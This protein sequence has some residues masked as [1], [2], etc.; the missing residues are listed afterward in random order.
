MST[1]THDVDIFET[2]YDIQQFDLF[3]VGKDDQENFKIDL[4][5]MYNSCY[6][7]E[8]FFSPFLEFHVTALDSLGLFKN[9]PLRGGELLRIKFKIKS[10]IIQEEKTLAFRLISWNKTT[11]KDNLELYK[12][13]IFMSK[14]YYYNLSSRINWA[15]PKETEL[16]S[17]VENICEKLLHCKE[18]NKEF[19]G[20]ESNKLGNSSSNQFTFTNAPPLD[21]IFKLIPFTSTKDDNK[22]CDYLFFECLDAGNKVK[23]NFK[24]LNK[25]IKDA[26]EKWTFL[27]YP[28]QNSKKENSVGMIGDFRQKN[29]IPVRRFKIKESKNTINGI[30]NSL[31]GGAV[32]TINPLLKSFKKSE[33]DVN[34]LHKSCARLNEKSWYISEEGQHFF[35]QATQDERAQQALQHFNVFKIINSN[36][37]N[38]DV[39]D[40]NSD[41]LRKFNLNVLYQYQIIVDIAGNTDLFLGWKTKFKIPEQDVMGNSVDHSY[42]SNTVFL[43]TAIKHI[44]DGKEYTMLVELS[45]DGESTHDL[46]SRFTEDK[47]PWIQKVNKQIAGKDDSPLSGILSHIF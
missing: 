14:E 25:I 24:S 29:I 47:L 15:Y 38:N 23:F 21:C 35:T 36:I 33:I 18:E 3:P 27:W 16:T 12:P 43:I 32:N 20:H 31:A 17:I 22:L 46:Y 26:K 2:K 40:A 7:Y 9:M 5:G 37:F 41:L 34:A 4:R 28:M 19:E 30:E 8:N 42:D 44:F 10:N 45:S 1:Y 11:I 13:M 39:R 6:L